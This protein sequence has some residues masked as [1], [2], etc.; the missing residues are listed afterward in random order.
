MKSI[1]FD[2][3]DKQS[4]D[5][6]RRELIAVKYE[7]KRKADICSE[8]IAAMLADLINENLMNVEIADDLKDVTTHQQVFAAPG[9]EA[10]ANGNMVTVYGENAVFI[11]FG[12]GVYHNSGTNN[13]LADKVEFDT[14]IGSYGKGQGNKKY[15]FVAHNLISCGTP[16]YMPIYKAIEEIKPK[17]PSLIR[18][19]FL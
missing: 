6:A 2:A 7:W 16:A 17:I 15:W 4:V 8:M 9:V 11:E 10:R 14:A 13:P 19:V 12:A 1:R 5:H 18:Q 3:F